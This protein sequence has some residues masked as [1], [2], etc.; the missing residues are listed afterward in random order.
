MAD[1][2]ENKQEITL[3]SVENFLQVLKNAQT[4]VWNGPLGQIEDEKYQAG[5]Q[6]S[7]W[8]DC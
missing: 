4:I 5:T 6:N 2:I 7:S 1:T 3:R 8:R